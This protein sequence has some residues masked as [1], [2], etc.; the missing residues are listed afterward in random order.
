M[1]APEHSRPGCVPAASEDGTL[2]FTSG[3]R[4]FFSLEPFHRL[5]FENLRAVL[6]E[7]GEWF[8]ARDGKLF[9]K[10]R[11]GNNTIFQK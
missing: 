2:Q 6:D 9:Y 8:L 5:Y 1:P 7:P 3:S 4:A 10:P 11:P